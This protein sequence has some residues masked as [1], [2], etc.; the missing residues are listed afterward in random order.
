MMHPFIIS[1]SFAEYRSFHT[2]EQHPIHVF[3]ARG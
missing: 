2:G 1:V 3:N